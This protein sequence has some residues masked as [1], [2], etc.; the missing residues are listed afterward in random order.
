MGD[1]DC[2]QSTSHPNRI[3]I[4]SLVARK[5]ISVKSIKCFIIIMVVQFKVF[6]KASPNGKLTLYMGRRDFVDHVTS[7]DPVDGVLVVDTGYLQGRKVYGQLVCSF[8]YG[9][10][11]DEIMGLNFQK[12]LFLASNQI[13]PPADIEPTK[14]QERLI[15]SWG[16]TPTPSPSKCH[17]TPHR[18][19]PSNPVAM[20]KASPAVSSTTSRSSSENPM[21]TRVIKGQQFCLESA[22]FSL[23]Q[24]SKAANHVPLSAKTS[25]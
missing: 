20:R 14:L 21:K 5:W 23:L 4:C 12:D 8:R 11:D 22:E 6:K 18:R 10:E 2:N 3:Y 15:K 16:P 9:R 13:Y 25:C 7:V 19:S 17:R 24:R 1:T